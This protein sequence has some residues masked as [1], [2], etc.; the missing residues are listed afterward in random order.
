MGPDNWKQQ[1]V[2]FLQ[3]HNQGL[4]K[5]FL[6]VSWTL[7]GLATQERDYRA[8]SHHQGLRQLFLTVSWDSRAYYYPVNRA[9]KGL[10]P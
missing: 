8:M 6:K 2:R 4:R 3:K 9:C 1:Q 5:L 7:T 10:A